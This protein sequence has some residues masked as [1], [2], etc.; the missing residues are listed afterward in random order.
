MNFMKKDESKSIIPLERIERAIYVIRGHKIILDQDLA[1]L[2]GAETKQL[3]RALSRNK[4]RF[5]GDFA[6]QLTIEEWN[7]LRCQI[8]TSNIG[9]GGRRYLPFV[10]TEH[11]VVMVAN[12]LKSKRAVWVSIEIVRAFVRLRQAM[13]SHK[14]MSKE[15]S[16]LKS[17]L[18]KHS[19]QTNREFKR[20]WQA[21][22]KLAKPPDG[23]EQRKIGFDI[24]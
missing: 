21:I 15:L 19:N 1:A 20:I 18:L 14:E 17:F 12:I 13:V 4:E 22:E 23:K 7:S 24:S 2:Y 11:G 10:F 5:P 3:N 8:G 16:E 6:F 9:R